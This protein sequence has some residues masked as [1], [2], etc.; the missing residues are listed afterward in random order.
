M[1]VRI[2]DQADLF[3][4]KTLILIV[5]GNLFLS[6]RDIGFTEDFRSRS[7]L[8]RGGFPSLP[9]I[10][11]ATDPLVLF[12]DFLAGSVLQHRGLQCA[13]VLPS[14]VRCLR[15][16]L[17][18]RHVTP[19]RVLHSNLVVAGGELVETRAARRK[20]PPGRLLS[21]IRRLTVVNLLI[22]LAR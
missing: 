9:S 3:D 16:G 13:L 8:W 14:D 22:P 12:G 10:S 20:I 17:T 6:L 21:G 1:S 18:L 4:L 11:S 19:E 2:L 5:V 7:G 15:T